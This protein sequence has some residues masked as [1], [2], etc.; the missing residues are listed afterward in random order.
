M[1]GASAWNRER[2]GLADSLAG[3]VRLGQQRQ[4]LGV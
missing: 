1:A 3:S 2:E 4:P